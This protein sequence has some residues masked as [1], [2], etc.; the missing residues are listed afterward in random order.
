[1]DV[2][3]GR[4]DSEPEPELNALANSNAPSHTARSDTH[5]EPKAEASTSAGTDAEIGVNDRRVRFRGERFPETSPGRILGPGV[6]GGTAWENF[7]TS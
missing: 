7:K 2:R 6:D 5:A 4:P 1:M 3:L